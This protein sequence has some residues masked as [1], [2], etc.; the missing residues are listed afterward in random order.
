MAGGEAATRILVAQT[1]GRDFAH[2]GVPD[3]AANRVLWGKVAASL[4][5]HPEGLQVEVPFDHA[6]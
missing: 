2:S 6:S 5:D 4:R 1:T 3:T